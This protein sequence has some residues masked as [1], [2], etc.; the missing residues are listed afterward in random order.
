MYRDLIG[1]GTCFIP[2][3]YSEEAAAGHMVP[4]IIEE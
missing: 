1:T 2:I 4:H 3:Y